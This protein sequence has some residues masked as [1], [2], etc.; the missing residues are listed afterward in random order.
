MLIHPSPS[1]ININI[2]PF[3]P[4]GWSKF[5]ANLTAICKSDFRGNWSENRV[6]LQIHWFI[7]GFRATLLASIGYIWLYWSNLSDYK[8]LAILIDIDW[9]WLILIDIVWYWLILIDID[10]YWLILIDIDWYWLILID[11]DWYWLILIDIDW[12]WLILLDIDWYWLIVI[13]ID[14]YWLILIDIDW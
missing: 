14:W 10:W 13:D 4:F 1:Y 8:S 11:I 9:Y 5:Q 7:N 2:H 6:P 3:F 12:Y